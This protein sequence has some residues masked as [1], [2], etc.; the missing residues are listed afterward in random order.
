MS[1]VTKDFHFVVHIIRPQKHARMQLLV[2]SDEVVPAV[3]SLNIRERFHTIDLILGCG[4]LPYYYLEYVVTMLGVPC[5][6]VHGNHDAPELTGGGDVVYEARGCTLLEDRCVMYA[7]WLLAGLGGSM[8]YNA[9]SRYQYSESAMVLRVMRLL[10]RLLLNRLRYGRMLDMLL[11]HA[12]P[13]G[14]HQGTD[15]A[16][17]GFRSLRWLIAWAQPPYL[18]HG[19]IHQSYRMGNQQPVRHGATTV[20]NAVGYR[21]LQVGTPLAYG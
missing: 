15:L 5:F 14:I 11:T 16:H 2:L 21:V 19:H 9:E 12:P 3:Y 13:A 18:F 6:Y 4:D 17:R 7:G 1:I 8:R 20:I 10:P